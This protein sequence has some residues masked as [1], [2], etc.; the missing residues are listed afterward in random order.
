M[1]AASWAL[2][3]AGALL[4]PL[5]AEKRLVAL[6]FKRAHA[7]SPMAEAVAPHEA[8]PDA[9]L[10]VVDV[11]AATAIAGAAQARALYTARWIALFRQ[12]FKLDLVVLAVYF[13]FA[14]VAAFVP[15]DNPK[16]VGPGLVVAFWYALACLLRNHFHK[17]RFSTD[18][19]QLPQPFN[20]TAGD[21]LRGPYAWLAAMALRLLL[22]LMRA[23][24]ALVFVL[25]ALFVASIAF[26]E[27]GPAMGWALI[28]AAAVHGVLTLWF[29]Q[30]VQRH[31]GLKLLVLRVF[32]IDEKA[33]FTFGN[34]LAV[35]GFFGSYFTVID[36]SYWRHAN[37]LWSRAALARV[38]GTLLLFLLVT[39]AIEGPAEALGATMVSA[40]A[41]PAAAV[42]V[43]A[44]I[45]IWTWRSVD[46]QCIRG[47]DHM[48]RVLGR[49]E[50]RPRAA[51]VAFRN[52]TVPCHDDTWK[53]AVDE[54]A[55]SA[56]VV[57]M[58]L[59]GFSEA[60]K[61]CA[62]EVNFLLDRLPIEQV[63]FLIDRSSDRELVGS[64][65]ADCWQVLDVHSP[66]LAKRAPRATLYAAGH[67]DERD[68][69]GLLNLLLTVAAKAAQTRPSSA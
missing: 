38:L 63:V 15:S 11:W 12:A 52:L 49:L 21:M 19:A 54:F 62:F 65:I 56:H 6:M 45:G 14:A 64:L 22:P 32:G 18:D 5:L 31:A 26:K 42:L 10:R 7:T 34:V 17:P 61:G 68:V 41:L 4:L 3:G 35:W 40:S 48:L 37:K 39:I 27:G 16:V 28:A 46:A 13:G 30:R 53:I 25:L 36:P 44:G 47:R 23:W 8:A 9:P 20:P 66:N 58:D 2:V 55:R 1:V 29:V 69:Q 67:E 50:R 24:M 57:L 33:A 51:N 59:R 60:R 43:L